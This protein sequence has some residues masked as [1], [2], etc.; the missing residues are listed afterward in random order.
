MSQDALETALTVLTDARGT[1]RVMRDG[2]RPFREP[3]SDREAADMLTGTIEGIDE[4]LVKVKAAMRARAAAPLTFAALREANV[5]RCSS[6][7]HPLSHWNPLEWAGAMAGEAGEACNVAKKLR[8]LDGTPQTRER[9]IDPTLGLDGTREALTRDLGA[10]LA[11][12]VIYA[13]LLAA[14]VGIDLGAIVAQK[15]NEVSRRVGSPVLLIAGQE[16]RRG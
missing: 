7:F 6:A 4:A 15:F 16:E 5:K 2:D 11:D 9:Q 13:D 1:C 10:E 3:E 14:C 12:V 8:R